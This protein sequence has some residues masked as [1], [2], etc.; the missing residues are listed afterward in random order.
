M[1]E[2]ATQAVSAY[3]FRVDIAPDAAGS[4]GAYVELGEIRDDDL[5]IPEDSASVMR[6]RTNQS[7]SGYTEAVMSR[8]KELAEFTINVNFV[9]GITLQSTVLGYFKNRTQAWI[10]ITN[11]ATTMVFICKVYCTKRKFEFKG[12]EVDR[13]MLTFTPNGGPQAGSTFLGA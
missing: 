6:F 7:P 1:T 8:A 3:G 9:P 10:K 11:A 5:D 13:A 12:T 2:V 4:P